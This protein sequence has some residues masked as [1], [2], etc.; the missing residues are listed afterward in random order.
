MTVAIVRSGSS[1]PLQ[2]W[3]RCRW[4][5]AADARCRQQPSPWKHRRRVSVSMP[6][7]EV[8]PLDA[9]W[10]W[11]WLEV[12]TCKLSQVCRHREETVEA[13]RS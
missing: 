8:K 1:E 3:N 12:F 6:T 4:M 2:E 10:H 11:G 7:I 13:L 5:A 9:K